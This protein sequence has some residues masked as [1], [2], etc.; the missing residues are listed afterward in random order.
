VNFEFTGRSDGWFAVGFGGST[1]ANTYGIIAMQDGSVEERRLS[2]SGGTVLNPELTVLSNTVSGN[3]RTLVVERDLLISDTDYYDF[4][5][6][7]STIALISASA[8]GGFGYHGADN[9]SS[10]SISVAAVPEPGAL[11]MFGLASLSFLRLRR[12]RF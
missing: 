7:E 3:L 1:M 12:R 6:T 10:G 2:Y 9:R 11:A 5:T 8:A 4:P